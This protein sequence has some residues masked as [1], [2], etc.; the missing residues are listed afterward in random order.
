LEEQ[1]NI[2]KNDKLEKSYNPQ[3]IVKQEIN[4]KI[5]NSSFILI[6]RQAHKGN[7]CTACAIVAMCASSNLV[8]CS[9]QHEKKSV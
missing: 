2:L 4:E 1:I 9:L 7:S 8:F 5:D 6:G 3:V